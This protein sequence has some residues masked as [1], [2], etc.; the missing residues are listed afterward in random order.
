MIGSSSHLE[1]ALPHGLGEH[2]R[3]QQPPNVQTIAESFEQVVRA[4]I[5]TLEAKLCAELKELRASLFKPDGL[6]RRTARASSSTCA[7]EPKGT[8]VQDLGKPH[9]WVFRSMRTFAAGAELNDLEMVRSA[10]AAVVDVPSDRHKLELL[11]SVIPKGTGPLARAVRRTSSTASAQARR[12][13]R[14]NADQ[15]KDQDVMQRQDSHDSAVVSTWFGSEGEDA[16]NHVADSSGGSA[17]RVGAW[18]ELNSA[19]VDAGRCASRNTSTTSSASFAFVQNVPTSVTCKSVMPLNPSIHIP[20]EAIPSLP[21]S[22]GSPSVRSEVTSQVSRR[23]SRLLSTIPSMA[24]LSTMSMSQFMSRPSPQEL[25]IRLVRHLRFESLTMLVIA[26]NTAMVGITT[27][28]C[29]RNLTEAVPYEYDLI[30]AVLATYFAVELALRLFAFRCAFFKMPGWRWNV[31]DLLLVLLQIV[32]EVMTCAM[33]GQSNVP[34]ALNLVRLLRILRLIRIL[35]V[36]R[37]LRYMTELRTIV[38]SM[39]SS[40]KPLLST[41]VLLALVVYVAG[42]YFAQMALTHRIDNAGE[43]SARELDGHFSS[44]GSAVMSLFQTVTGGLEWRHLVDPLVEHIS[45]TMGVVF[46]FYIMF[47]SL[48]LMNIVTGVFVETALQRGREDK[49][50]Y[51]INHLRDLFGVL[52]QNNNGMISWSELQEHLGDS[53][54]LAFLQE[55]DIDVSEARGLFHLLDRDSSGTIDADEF[56]SGCLRLRGPAKALDMQLMMRELAEQ[57]KAIHMLLGDQPTQAE[58]GTPPSAGGWVP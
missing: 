16:P 11:P 43:A 17:A 19:S 38:V 34:I 18:L 48:A 25:A 31:L 30:S 6:E 37:L 44:V 20:P 39:S 35:R 56:L 52:D 5:A 7:N 13:R 40:M 27:D 51:M 42:I 45:P 26:M 21:E 46:A 54:L 3:R 15:R 58:P 28:Y 8:G 24:S 36:V 41:I 49:N 10:S 33:S 23:R 57:G 29:A 22:L 53:K 4:Q 1:E 9:A 32:D 47:T 12:L 14:T 50:V 2:E 55:I